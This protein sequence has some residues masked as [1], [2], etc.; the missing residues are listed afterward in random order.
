MM[1]FDS[2]VSLSKNDLDIYAKRLGLVLP[3]DYV[4]FM[5]LHN[6]GTPEEDVVFDFIDPVT[7]KKIT[8]DIRGFYIFYDCEN[9]NYDNIVS[10]YNMMSNEG[11]I[12]ENFLPFADDS[13]DNVVCMCLS[14]EHYGEIYYCDRELEEPDSGYLVM[15]KI[16]D[17]FTDFL[18]KVYIFTE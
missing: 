13:G 16:A 5:T 10:V 1:L 7:R 4:E 8:T 3:N 15:S 12:R 14:K 6:G 2:G 9:D 11:E 18:D 17:S